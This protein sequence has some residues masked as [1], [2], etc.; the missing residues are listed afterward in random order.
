MLAMGSTGQDHTLF[1]ELA[2]EGPARD[3]VLR[4]TPEDAETSGDGMELAGFKLWD[5]TE[6]DARVEVAFSLQGIYGAMTVDLTREDGDWKLDVPTAG[7]F[8]F[9]V[10]DPSLDGFVRMSPTGG[11]TNG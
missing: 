7:D 9:R 1:A 8:P 4:E 10:V 6:D 11:A 3:Q 5:F 2:A